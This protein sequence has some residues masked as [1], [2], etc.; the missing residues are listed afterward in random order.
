MI[1]QV[2]MKQATINQIEGHS[3][4]TH[5]DEAHS[6]HD[7]AGHDHSGNDPHIWLDPANAKILVLAIAEKLAETD[8]TNA[9]RYRKNAAETAE[10]LGKL[11]QEIS[12]RLTPVAQNGFLVFHDGY[13]YFER[14]FKLNHQG[15][16]HINPE[17]AAS[18]AR[19]RKLQNRLEKN[20]LR[21]LF[22]EP[23]F[24]TAIL[25]TIAEKTDVRIVELDPL[26][27]AL[28]PGPDLYFQLLRNM[29]ASFEKCLAS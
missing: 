16:V 7:H 15:A 17:Q 20:N 18:A 26:G 10:T 13:Q 21:C 5:S 8:E 25:K 14:A 2:M 22:S 1:T 3:D 19:I 28:V 12:E 29:T 9:A 4:E 6:D 27:Q 24:N 11:N 23:Q